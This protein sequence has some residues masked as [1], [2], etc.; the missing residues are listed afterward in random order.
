MLITVVQLCFAN[1]HAHSQLYDICY[2][3]LATVIYL[4]SPVRQNDR[5]PNLGRNP[6]RALVM[7]HKPDVI[8]A[9]PTAP[10][11]MMGI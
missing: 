5:W 6:A 3:T 2:I 11:R 7:R 8:P 4:P 9:P 10:V 1:L